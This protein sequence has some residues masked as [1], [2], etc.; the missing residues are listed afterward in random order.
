[1]L[2]EARLELMS[3]DV[4]SLASGGACAVGGFFGIR[5]GCDCTRCW[6][7]CSRDRRCFSS[8]CYSPGK[9]TFAFWTGDLV[10]LVVGDA[11]EKFEMPRSS[12]ALRRKMSAE[13]LTMEV[14]L[15]TGPRPG[16]IS[17]G[18]VMSMAVLH[19]KWTTSYLCSFLMELSCSSFALCSSST[20][21]IISFTTLIMALNWLS[22]RPFSMVSGIRNG[23]TLQAITSLVRP[24]FLCVMASL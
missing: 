3:V 20:A 6:S 8:R 24:S 13:Q 4:K 21:P 14:G 16:T 19:S 5:A 9:H 1:M 23:I 2:R 18:L 22:V 7:S 10:A 11:D 17:L 12:S 15:L